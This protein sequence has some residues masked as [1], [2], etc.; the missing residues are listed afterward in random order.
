MRQVARA[1]YTLIELMITLAV[2]GVIAAL[3]AQYFQHAT[4]RSKR[5][6][7][8][9]VLRGIYQSQEQYFTTHGTFAGTFDD[10]GFEIAG[11][12][13]VSATELKG[14]R[15]RFLLS[16]PDGPT[17]FYVTALGELDSDPWPDVVTI[18]E[19]R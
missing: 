3:A 11:G 18:R 14:G 5:V 12:S 4:A 16:R 9:A 19:K 13:R 2:A 7:A 15:Y 17:S 6:E 1:G 10:L 8:F